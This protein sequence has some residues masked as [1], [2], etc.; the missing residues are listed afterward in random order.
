ML[1]KASFYYP[2]NLPV[3]AMVEK[4]RTGEIDPRLWIPLEDIYDGWEKAGQV[5]QE[6]YGAG[7]PFGMV[8]RH[9]WR[10]PDGKFMVY[11]DYPIK[12]FSTVHGGQAMFHVLGDPRLSCRMR[13]IP[14]GRKGLPV[15][16]VTTEREDGS[17]TLEGRETEEG[18]LEFS[19]SGDRN[20]IVRWQA[21]ESKP[22]SRK[23]TNHSNGRRGRKK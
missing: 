16:E 4:P 9:Y 14:T 19:V 22:P 15:I 2:P 23:K 17:E 11:I 20:V 21:I 6:V 3:E 13:I 12:A 10:V 8:P 18:H 1:Y 7:M 5:G